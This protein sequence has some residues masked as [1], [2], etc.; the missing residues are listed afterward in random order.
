MSSLRF[1]GS[2]MFWDLM[3]CMK[4]MSLCLWCSSTCKDERVSVHSVYPV[5]NQIS[6]WPCGLS[7]CP[8]TGK[9][10]SLIPG[11]QC[12]RLALR[13]KSQIG[14]KSLRHTS[15]MTRGC[16]CTS[17]CHTLQKQEMG[18][19]PMGLVAQQGLGLL[20]PVY[21]RICQVP[22]RAKVWASRKVNVYSF[23]AFKKA[24][25]LSKVLYHAAIIYSDFQWHVSSENFV[26]SD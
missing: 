12:L 24:A 18:S 17:S 21:K 19:C 6:A 4:A 25:E 8:E 20:H 15:I 7:A 13:I 23:P 26:I 2:S 16:A 22:L 10:R 5:C 1:R 3:S 14:S 9:S 11:T